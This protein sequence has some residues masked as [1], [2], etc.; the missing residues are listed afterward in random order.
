M[1]SIGA[2]LQVVILQ[3]SKEIIEILWFACISSLENFGNNVG[4]LLIIICL[5]GIR[6]VP[7]MRHTEFQDN[8]CSRWQLGS[9]LDKSWKRP[10][11]GSHTRRERD[12]QQ[13]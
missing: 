9:A 11:L 10:R 2:K 4:T 1:F 5:V 7:R 6:E 13:P 8:Y 12:E 3:K